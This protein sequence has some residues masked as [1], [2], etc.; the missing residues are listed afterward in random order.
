MEDR[1]QKE[2]KRKSFFLTE[3]AA[4]PP[5]LVLSSYRKAFIFLFFLICVSAS[6]ASFGAYFG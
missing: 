5:S 6:L 1:E 3:A 4:E 2:T